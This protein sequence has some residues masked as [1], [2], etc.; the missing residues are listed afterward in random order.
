M[1]IGELEGKRKLIRIECSCG[2]VWI[3]YGKNKNF[4]K[5]QR[6]YFI[7]KHYDHD[8]TSFEVIST[9]TKAR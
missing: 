6:Q 8:L 5:R 7:A 2:A 3:R 1:K 9:L 4:D